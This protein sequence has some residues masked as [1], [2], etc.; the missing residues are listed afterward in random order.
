MANTRSRMMQEMR[1]QQGLDKPAVSGLLAH[2]ITS[3]F[4]SGMLS[5]L[6]F[7]S[8]VIAFLDYNNF[9][10]TGNYLVLLIGTII[11]MAFLRG[12]GAWQEDHNTYQKDLANARHTYEPRA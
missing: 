5:L 7:G 6:A 4:S 10:A 9:P 2:I 8:A 3:L 12:C 1:E 11:V